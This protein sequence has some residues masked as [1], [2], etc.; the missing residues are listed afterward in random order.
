MKHT[1]LFTMLVGAALAFTAVATPV[2][3]DDASK[4]GKQTSEYPNATRAEPKLDLKSEKDQKALQQGQEAFAAGDNAKAAQILQPVID[5]S[6]SKY[7]QA[8]ALYLMANITYKNG[9]VKGAI[10]QSK[11]SLDIGVLPND[12]YFQEMLALSQLYYADQQYQASLDTIAKWRA[13]GK[14]ETAESYGLEGIDDYNLQKYPEAIAAIQK[15]KTLTDKPQDSW[16][17]VLMASYAES[18]QGADAAKMAEAEYEKNPTDSGTLHNASAILLQ[19]QDYADAIKVLEQG[20]ANGALKDEADWILLVKAYLLQA[21]NGGDGK[22]GGAKALAAFDDGVAKGAIKP[23]A[24]NYKL[25]GDAA[26]I[27]ED[28]TKAI[29]YYQKGAAVATDGELDVALGS[30]YFQDQNFS[31][32][33]KYL[34]QGIGKGVQHKGRAYMMLAESDRQ[35]KDKAGAIAA[36]KQAAQ[37]PETASKAQEWLSK[38]PGGK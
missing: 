22:S 1:P 21:Q 8:L 9:D 32:A 26:V 13:E 7:A 11:R 20:R 5:K 24:A 31:D 25:A 30:V 19:Q 10:E 37:D 4:K 34:T 12:N 14:R 16:N 17:Q 38:T 29:G 15:A 6:D 27:G 35:L 23:S 28:D 18:G 36:M 33:R 2:H 3:A